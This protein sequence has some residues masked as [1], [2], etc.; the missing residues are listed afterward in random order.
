MGRLQPETLHKPLYLSLHVWFVS[1]ND[2][3][4]KTLKW[5]PFTK[6]PLFGGEAVVGGDA[7]HLTPWETEARQDLESEASL[8]YKVKPSFKRPINK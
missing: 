2:T 4:D 7:C 1:A 6:H 8:S 3:R 5:A